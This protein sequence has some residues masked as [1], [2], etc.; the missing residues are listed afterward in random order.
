[1]NKDDLMKEISY[2]KES[3]IFRWI[4]KSQKRKVDDIAGTLTELGYIVICIN[5]KRY[6]AHYLAW[7]YLHGET[8]RLI[9]HINGNPA[10]NRISTLRKATSSQNAQNSKI[11]KN[12]KTGLKGVTF[13]PRTGRWEAQICCNRKS[14]YLGSFLT[15]QEA[16]EAYCKKSIELHGE[17]SRI[18]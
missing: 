17:F 6:R 10:D 13:K 3:G 12:N 1:M 9:D 7:I 2:E 5:R 11:S 14:I 18:N 16:H 15:P 8:P 4:K